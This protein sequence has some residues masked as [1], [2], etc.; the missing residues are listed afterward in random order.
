MA[1]KTPTFFIY[2]FILSFYF[3]FCLFSLLYN[4]KNGKHCFTLP[5]L[6]SNT[7]YDRLVMKKRHSL[8]FIVFVKHKLPAWVYQKEEIVDLPLQV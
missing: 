7:C 4:K 6:C 8:C 3:F 2:L 1:Q 5:L